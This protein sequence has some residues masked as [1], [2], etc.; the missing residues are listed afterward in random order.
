MRPPKLNLYIPY[1][2]KIKDI[3]N[4]L[5]VNIWLVGGFLRDFYLKV[6]KEFLDFDFCV[7]K[8]TLDFVEE[9]SKLFS[10]KYIVLDEKN[11]TF[12]VIIKR[13]EKIYNYDFTNMRGRDIKEDLFLRD[14]SINTLA[15]N[16][17]DKKLKVLDYF[18]AKKDLDNRIIKVV[19]E[20]NFLDDPLRILRVFFFMANYN[21][22]I[23]NNTLKAISKYKNFLNKV[24]GERINEELFKILKAKKSYK[25]IKLMSNLKIIDIIIPQIKN[26]RGV[27][28]GR[29]HHL[30]VWEHS[31]ETLL[32]FENMYNKKLYKDRDLFRYLNTE[33]IQNRTRLQVI[34]LACL[35][36]DIGKPKAKSKKKKKTIFY[37]HE[38]IGK[39]IIEKITERLKFANKIK[40]TLQRL[41]F[42]HLRPGYLADQVKPSKR[43]IYR[44]F[45]D[46]S[47]DGISVILLS[48][49]DWK[50]T[51]GPLTSKIRRKKH[52]DVMFKIIKDYFNE[53]NKKPL[54]KLIDGYDIMDRFNIQPSPLVGKILKKIKEEQA[55]GNINTKKEALK[56]AREVIKNENQRYRDISN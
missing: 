39:E 8:N 24:S 10:F 28:Q 7:E 22:K 44:F 21:F 20:K 31:L 47:E 2:S 33:I 4:K 1:I 18:N 15:I 17:N 45:R 38:K 52:Q 13:K 40:E 5:G 41:V 37:C 51:R 12:R 34:K 36:H 56:I 29:Y 11:L 43:A 49:A 26:T 53:K 54:P 55:L 46:T 9:F 19:N 14:F 48:L 32:Q 25:A 42:W 16:I 30:D 50:A 3:A 23:E 6:D 27:S 35:L